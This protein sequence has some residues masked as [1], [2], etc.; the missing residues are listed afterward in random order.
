MKGIIP[1]HH[2][3]IETRSEWKS[4]ANA[5]DDPSFTA[6]TD[7]DGAET[8]EKRDEERTPKQAGEG[9]GE[10]DTEHRRPREVGSQEGEKRVTVTRDVQVGHKRERRGTE[11]EKRRG[12]Q[13]E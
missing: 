12:S 6:D 2:L 7:Q 8:G 10:R 13:E 9:R 5:N 3:E 11:K 1:L 4:H